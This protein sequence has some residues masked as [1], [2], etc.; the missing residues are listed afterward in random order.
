MGQYSH[1]AVARILLVQ[2]RP[3]TNGTDGASSCC[4]LELSGELTRH[5]H[6]WISFG[7]ALDDSWLRTIGPV[8][9]TMIR[10]RC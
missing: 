6:S 5:L 4:R 8:S 2:A 1:A 7:S 10:D 9:N 3:K